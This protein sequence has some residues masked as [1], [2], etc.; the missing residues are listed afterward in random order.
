M[1]LFN[2]ENSILPR[3]FVPS[4]QSLFCLHFLPLLVCSHHK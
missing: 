3:D 1:L 4:I 2:L